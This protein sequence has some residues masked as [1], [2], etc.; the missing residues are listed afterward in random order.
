[1][2]ASPSP[3]TPRR[4]DVALARLRERSAVISM[5]ERDIAE[6]VATDA[7]QALV[8]AYAASELRAGQA[9]EVTSC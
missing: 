1:M 7:T 2:D 8:L 3:S 4:I 5:M 9:Q 6:I